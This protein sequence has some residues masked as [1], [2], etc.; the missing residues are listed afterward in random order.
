[1]CRDALFF[2]A[3]LLLVASNLPSQLL[4]YN[5]LIAQDFIDLQLS[6][7]ESR[8]PASLVILNGNRLVRLITVL[9]L[10][11]HVQFCLFPLLRWEQR[12]GVHEADDG[13]FCTAL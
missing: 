10:F 13:I 1:M 5:A 2:S 9:L 7:P 12:C 4:Y 6:F 3:L 8:I 11:E